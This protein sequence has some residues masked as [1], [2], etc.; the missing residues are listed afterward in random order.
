MKEPYAEDLA[1]HSDHESCAEDRKVLRE[2]L[3]SGI[4]RLGIEPRKCNSECRRG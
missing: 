4:Y 2:A 3:D 1:N